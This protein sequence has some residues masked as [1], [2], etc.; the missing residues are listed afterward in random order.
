M[1]RAT[2]IIYV[3][4]LI[5]VISGIALFVRTN[6]AAATGSLATGAVLFAVGATLSSGK[7]KQ[8]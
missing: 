4:A 5:C 8:G 2:M 7:R 1:S 6:G 3:C